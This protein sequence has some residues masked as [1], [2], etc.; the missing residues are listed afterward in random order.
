MAVSASDLAR[1]CLVAA[2]HEGIEPKEI[3]DVFPRL[4]DFFAQALVADKLALRKPAAGH[5][6]SP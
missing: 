1:R 6:T 5:P 4:V 2:L 3:E